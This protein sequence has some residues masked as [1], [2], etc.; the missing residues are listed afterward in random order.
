[1]TQIMFLFYARRRVRLYNTISDPSENNDIS[2]KNPQ[3]TTSAF[4]QN[5]HLKTGFQKLGFG[6]GCTN[7]TCFFLKQNLMF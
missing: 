2:E 3:V 5:I 6:Y 4:I 1:M 7:E